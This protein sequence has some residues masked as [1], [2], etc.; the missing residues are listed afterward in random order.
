MQRQI[1]RLSG[2]EWEGRCPKR[3]NTCLY[4][5]TNWILEVHHTASI[6][7]SVW[8]TLMCIVVELAEEGFSVWKHSEYIRHTWAALQTPLLFIHWFADL[9]SHPL[10]PL[11]LPTIFFLFILSQPIS[12]IFQP[13]LNILVVWQPRSRSWLI[14]ANLSLSEICGTSLP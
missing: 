14:L 13:K 5:E 10:P 11:A 1:L 8:D 7:A 3:W 9:V 12:D 4:I 2:R 6:I